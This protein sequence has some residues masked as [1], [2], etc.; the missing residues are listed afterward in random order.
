MV[1]KGRGPCRLIKGKWTAR[2]RKNMNKDRAAT[3]SMENTFK[4]NYL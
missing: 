4:E 3:L 1:V 2:P